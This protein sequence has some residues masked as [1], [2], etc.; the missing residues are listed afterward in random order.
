M[1]MTLQS[2][3]LGLRILL[4]CGLLA[5]VVPAAAEVLAWK[6]ESVRLDDGETASGF[7]NYDAATNAIN[8]FR[9]TVGGGTL[10]AFIYSPVTALARTTRECYFVHLGECVG[11]HQ[12]ITFLKRDDGTRTYKA[13][14]LD[15]L[16]FSSGT[17]LLP[18]VRPDGLPIGDVEAELHWIVHGAIAFDRGAS[19]WRLVDV[20]FSDGAIATGLFRFTAGSDFGKLDAFNVH[21]QGGAF[22]GVQFDLS[23]TQVD[24]S[25]DG[26][27]LSSK[28]H[29]DLYWGG[30]LD[31]ST[32]G[33]TVPL[34]SSSLEIA[35]RS[36]VGGEIVAGV[37][38]PSRAILLSVGLAAI[39]CAL[40]VGAGTRGIR[41][42]RTRSDGYHPS[43]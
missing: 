9:I 18:L 21:L 14:S 20:E 32:G 25:R 39:A 6:L 41:S 3:K 2:H 1:K 16:P 38:E 17:R 8:D 12:N 35:N 40:R 33:K 22:S 30:T 37:P 29:L 5:S 19:V 43:A 10:P 23:N 7:F 26:I 24:V 27:S 31:E 15:T 28:Q 4:G 36:I 11:D 34:D 42:T 13:L